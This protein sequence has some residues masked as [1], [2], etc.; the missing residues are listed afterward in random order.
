MVVAGTSRNT[1]GNTSY[2]ARLAFVVTVSSALLIVALLVLI[3]EDVSYSSADEKN[4]TTNTQN[5][6]T[7][8]ASSLCEPDIVYRAAGVPS[9]NGRNNLSTLLQKKGFESGAEVDVQ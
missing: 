9:I 6:R 4:D 7:R 8:Q 1:A 3:K 5:I 2:I